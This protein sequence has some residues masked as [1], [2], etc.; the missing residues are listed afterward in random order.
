M[1][2]SLTIQEIYRAGGFI[3][4]YLFLF[5]TLHLINEAK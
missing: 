5:I 4:L 1:Y 2:S 3:S